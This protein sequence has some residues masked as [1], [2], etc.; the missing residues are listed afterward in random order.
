MTD[1][2]RNEDGVDSDH[3][4]DLA[5]AFAIDALPADEAALFEA[6]LPGCE[7]C[8]AE[9]AGLWQVGA[10]LADAVS[11]EPP[12]ELRDRLLAEIGTT[13]QAPWDGQDLSPS[14][15]IDLAEHRRRRMSRYLL[16]GAAAVVA[17][18]ALSFSL[19]RPDRSAT[20]EL[21]A[22]PD[23]VRTELLGD[24]VVGEV[25][26]VWSP[27]SDRVAIIADGLADPGAGKIYALWFVLDD[28]VAPAALFA[29]DD[30]TVQEVLEVADLA[31]NGWGITIEPA[32]G[33]PQP[34]GEILYL[35][36]VT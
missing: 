1:D 27:E 6:H 13:R 7:R 25:E 24:G 36:T 32:A 20:E 12:P 22:A 33:S 5:P 26:V 18:F 21:I 30:G 23:A 4:H 34:T 9:V 35:G 11:A 28:G 31:A 3:P 8:R 10:D 2:P 17:V 19:L 14:A 29:P 16:A 15:S